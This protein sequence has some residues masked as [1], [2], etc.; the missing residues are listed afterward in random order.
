VTRTIG[1]GVLISGGGTTL[2][3]LI[4]KSK[5]GELPAEVKV[6]ISSR[7]DAY[8]LIRARNHGID[9]YVVPSRKYRPVGQPPDWVGMSAEVCKLL[10]RYEVDLVV[11]AGFMCQFVIPPRYEG[12]VMN[13][14]PA[15]LPGFCG[16]GLY[17]H[18]VHEAVLEHGVKVSGC[19]VHFADQRYDHGP[20][21]IQRPVA[22]LDDDTP[23]TLAQR[24]FAE[25]CIAYPEAIRL[26]AEGRLKVEGR[27][28]L[29]LAPQDPQKNI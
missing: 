20:I 11:L 24:V 23:E 1:L 15:L 6:V 9:H 2:E 13:I 17:G 19:T 10:D 22:V 27:R 29:I 7:A 5:A 12:R 4:A 25:E 28:V 21:I 16:P 14:H 3:N 26:F 18:K 8:G